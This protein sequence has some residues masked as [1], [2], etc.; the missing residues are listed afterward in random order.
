VIVGDVPIVVQ[1]RMGSHR[2]P[3]K[4]LADLAG[5][6]LLEWCLR[7][8]A[9]SGVGPVVLAT[10]TSPADD[11][12]VGLADRLGFQAIRGPEDDVLQ[13]FALVADYL[14]ARFFIRATADNP[15]VDM[16]APGRVVAAIEDGGADHVVEQGL[17]IGA[18]VEA[19]RTAALYQALAQTRD[20]YDREHV[21]PYLYRT[22]S[23]FLALTAPAPP[24]L[25]RPDLRLTVDT[26]DD[27]RFM[28]CV[29]GRTA[30]GGLAGLAAIIHAA[31]EVNAAERSLG[32][33]ETR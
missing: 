16:D 11:A 12:L 17:P 3:G 8:L 33:Q 18:A 19:V 30:E 32:L 1:A 9:A 6:P 14:H 5:R 20:P 27:L 4:V 26:S 7:R 2:L 13:R 23:R 21:T 22:P 28:R 10:T 31:D 25:Q 29:F 24:A 15:A